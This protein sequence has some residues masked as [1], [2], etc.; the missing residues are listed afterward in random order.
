[1]AKGRLALLLVAGALIA[2]AAADARPTLAGLEK[3]LMCVTC[4]IPL[5]EARSPQAES[6]RNLIRQLIREGKSEAQI[7]RQLVAEYGSPVLAL[8]S[9]S[10]FN[11][12][13]YLVPGLAVVAAALLLYAALRRWQRRG[14]RSPALEGAI[15][16]LAPDEE[17]RLRQELEQLRD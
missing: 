10:G 13:V 9:A 14:S 11:L 7:K 12:L 17:L 2:P 5:V 4:K 1:M 15:A 6:E 8:P 3:Q 16:P